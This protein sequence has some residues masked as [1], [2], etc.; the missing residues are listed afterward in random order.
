MIANS[1]HVALNCFLCDAHEAELRSVL[2][3][4]CL[5]ARLSYY[6]RG[7]NLIRPRVSLLLHLSPPPA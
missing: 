4:F 3:L 1:L 6:D 7:K 2:S 5:S